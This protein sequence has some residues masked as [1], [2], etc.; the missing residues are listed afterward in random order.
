MG[1]LWREN[2]LLDDRSFLSD[3]LGTRSVRSITVT[4]SLIGHPKNKRRQARQTFKLRRLEIEANFSRDLSNTTTFNEPE[5]SVNRENS[6]NDF[7]TN[8][9]TNYS[10]F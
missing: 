6:R 4:A 2:R 9:W 10:H 1:L 8:D 7:K 3:K 5:L